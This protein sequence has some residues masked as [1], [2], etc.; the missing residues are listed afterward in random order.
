MINLL[1]LFSY[2]KHSPG[3]V[4]YL[5][6]PTLFDTVA[7]DTTLNAIITIGSFLAFFVGIIVTSFLYKYLLSQ[8]YRFKSALE[9]R[10]SDE[11][12]SV[13]SMQEK[14]AILI[15][16]IWEVI[17]NGD[18]IYNLASLALALCGCIVHPLFFTFHI[19]GV[20]FSF[21]KL[22][23]VLAAIWGPIA[24]ITITLLLYIIME[25]LFA[26]IGYALFPEQFPNFS[27]DSLVHCF[28]F[29]LDATFKNNGGV[30]AGIAKIYTVNQDSE[31]VTISYGRAIY[32][33]LFGFIIVIIIIQ[34]L[35]GLIID[36]FRSLRNDTEAK[37][38]DLRNLCIVCSEKSEV[39]ER[40]SQMTF[41]EHNISVHNIWF[42]HMFIGYLTNKPKED[43]SGVESY[44][45]KNFKS[46]QVGWLPYA[47]Y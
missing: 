21:P 5:D 27:C 15:R 6:N 14:I 17:T 23:N 22:R 47:L 8:Y 1:L 41:A 20:V 38:A 44:I 16:L 36:K 25:Y 35:S 12:G 30:G 9:Y 32:D 24:A 28:L 40:N 45:Q 26:V 19:L 3:F 13:D 39:I 31:N 11:G 4:D 29:A 7:S 2:R 46:R 43:Y 18:L 37:E 10:S 42:Y 34:L 33:F